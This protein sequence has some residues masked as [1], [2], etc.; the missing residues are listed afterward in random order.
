MIGDERGRDLMIG[1]ELVKDDAKTRAVNEAKA[2]RKSCLKKGHLI[3]IRDILEKV[4]RIQT[5]KIIAEEE[6]QL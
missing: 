6:E 3:R 5:H 1:V 2:I 4:L